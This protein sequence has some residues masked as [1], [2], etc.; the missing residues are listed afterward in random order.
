MRNKTSGLRRLA[1][2]LLLML[3][4]TALDQWTKVLA[5]R[6]LSDGPN[7]LIPG[8]FELR[9]I[10]NRGA[11]FGILQNQQWFFIAV[12]AFFFLAAAYVLVRLPEDPRYRPVTV[13]AIFLMAGALGNLIDRIM[14]TYVRD[15]IYVSLIDF[16]VF[17]VAD[18]YVTC[19]AF[20]MILLVMLYYK[21]DDFAFLKWR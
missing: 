20:A 9:Y 7:V 6:Y 1:A 5:V 8:V 2:A 4:L 21:D 10:Q 19:S 14:L 17:N 18:I 11:A 13:I 3:P 12:T 15:F 16:P